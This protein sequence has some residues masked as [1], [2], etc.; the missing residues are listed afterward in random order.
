LAKRH[1]RW[2]GAVADFV[3]NNV[4]AAVARNGNHGVQ[5][6]KIN[7]ND[8]HLGLRRCVL[9]V[10]ERKGGARALKERQ[11]RRKKIARP[12]EMKALTW[13]SLLLN[14]SITK[15]IKMA[16]FSLQGDM[17][18]KFGLI[19][20]AKK[21]QQQPKA[22]SPAS[23]TK[24]TTTTPKRSIFDDSDDDAAYDEAPKTSKQVV[25]ESIR[26]ASIRSQN[27]H[28]VQK[29]HEAALEED[30]SI[31]DYDAVYDQMK[32]AERQDKLAREGAS[33]ERQVRPMIAH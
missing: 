20:P 6:A 18:K 12:A 2:S 16:S 1:E 13:P 23:T 25:E 10:G 15:S 14:Q 24:T 26:T 21:Q 3:A 4:D 33:Q 5:I 28:R 29:Q 11:R 31:F 27:T 8:R 7:S 17:K 32:S 9:S 22:P 19:V 30:A